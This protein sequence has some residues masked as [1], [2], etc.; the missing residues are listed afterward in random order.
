MFPSSFFLLFVLF[1]GLHAATEFILDALNY[2]HTA[3][4]AQPPEFYR[5]KIDVATFAK[6]K[7]YT[8][9]KLRFGM[10]TRLIQI[11]FF[12]L[13]I[14][15]R[16]LDALDGRAA[17]LAGES[18]LTHS[19]LFC[20][21]IGLYFAA[22]SL[23]FRIYQTF[24]VEERHGFNKTTPAVFVIDTI[25]GLVLSSLLATPVLYAVFGF[26]RF[27]G[28][29]WWLWSWLA[30][31]AFQTLIAAVFP[32]WIA[33]LFN[34]FTPL[35]D[36]A[37]KTHLEALA[38]KTKFK[39]SGIFTV[40]GSRRSG[41]SNAYFAGLGKFRR[42]AIFDTLVTQL[43]VDELAA[44]LAHEIGHSVKKH[45]LKGTLFSAAMT[46]AGFFVLSRLQNMPAF[47]AAFGVTVPSA[48]AAIVIFGMASDVF[49]FPLTP[50]LNAWSR[51]NEFEAD[52]FAAQTVGE[53]ESL[54]GALTKLSRENLSNPAPHPAY[55][56]Y[57][58]SHPTLPE[59]AAAIMSTA[60]NAHN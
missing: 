31:V 43:S 57:H 5:D 15:M 60:K 42:I 46:L 55:S 50:L 53:S 32:V 40:D 49:T 52:A 6:A 56:F 33:P 48:H 36:G 58:Y 11:A 38:R 21:F 13:L 39:M 7:A 9:D 4:Q 28:D 44:V 2:R 24:V 14:L 51:K 47:Y 37:L 17:R 41:H 19:V 29:S 22:I 8:L 20:F 25:K 16:G 59:R 18:S 27:T 30:V 12:W 3:Q 34:K 1:Y 45:I 10:F 26:M 23:P 35:P 54:T